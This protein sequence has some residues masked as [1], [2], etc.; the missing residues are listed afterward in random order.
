MEAIAKVEVFY[1]DKSVKHLSRRHL[2][3]TLKAFKAYNVIKAV[4]YDN[5]GK[6][7]TAETILRYMKSQLCRGS[8]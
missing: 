1:D 2:K 5:K 4:A 7:S 6:T 3:L 8:F